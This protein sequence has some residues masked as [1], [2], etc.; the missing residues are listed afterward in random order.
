MSTDTG[1]RSVSHPVQERANG[2]T[3]VEAG[4][5][6]T[7]TLGLRVLPFR[8]GTRR[9]PLIFV[10][11]GR[12]GR[13]LPQCNTYSGC[14]AV[15]ATGAWSRRGA[16]APPLTWHGRMPSPNPLRVSPIDRDVGAGCQDVAPVRDR[17]DRHLRGTKPT[18]RHFAIGLVR[19]RD[20]LVTWRRSAFLTPRVRSVDHTQCDRSTPARNWRRSSRRR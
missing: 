20:S 15:A 1:C 9:K 6:L 2:T 7:S 13:R 5:I 16:S 18:G 12:V 14:D 11:R 19:L 3:R 10:E 17:T 8:K 4:P